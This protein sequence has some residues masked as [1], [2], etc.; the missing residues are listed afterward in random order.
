[1]ATAAG[2][3]YLVVDRSGARRWIV[4]VTVKG[5]K[6]RA[7]APLRTDFGMGGAGCCQKTLA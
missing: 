2:C 1:M 7:D 4:R 6:N 5:Q 3:I